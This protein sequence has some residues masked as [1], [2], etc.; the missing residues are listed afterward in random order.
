MDERQRQ[1][2]DFKEFFKDLDRTLQP[3]TSLRD[4]DQQGWIHE[5]NRDAEWK[6]VREGETA[7]AMAFIRR[8]FG[9]ELD[10]DEAE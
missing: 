9:T 1:N 10:D 7:I 6:K 3:M 8:G 2:S 4:V 5:S